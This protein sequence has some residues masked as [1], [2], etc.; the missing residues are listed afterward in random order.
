MNART[1]TGSTALH[2]AARD[3][4]AEI[5]RLLIAHGADVNAVEEDQMTSMHAAVAFDCHIAT[6]ELLIMAGADV[7]AKESNGFA[8]LFF[9]ASDGHD[10]VVRVLRSHGAK[11]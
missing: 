2:E 10:E 1:N 3:D 5:V 7:N 9:A 8:P 4:H 6:M 11:E